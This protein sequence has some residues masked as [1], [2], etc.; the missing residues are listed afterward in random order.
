L[1]DYNPTL[2]YLAVW[3]GEPPFV[4]VGG[5]T[6]MRFVIRSPAENEHVSHPHRSIKTTLALSDTISEMRRFVLAIVAAVVLGV[7]TWAL[8]PSTRFPAAFCQPVVR[9]VGVDV[10]AYSRYEA[11]HSSH[12]ITPPERALLTTLANDVRSAEQHAPT[13]QLRYE[14]ARYA[15]LFTNAKTY[16]DPVN[17]SN[18]F[19]GLARVQ[20]G[21]CGIRP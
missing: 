20:L 9:V 4:I 16:A 10:I 6:D 7:A 8:W 18:Y 5:M 19:D 11:V 2:A 1:T 12:S 3:C 14:L 15:A 13:S 17:A 21:A